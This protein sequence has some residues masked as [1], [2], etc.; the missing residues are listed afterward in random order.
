M[1]TNSE[2]FHSVHDRLMQDAI[3]RHDRAAAARGFDEAYFDTRVRRSD[4]SCCRA[5]TRSI[6][7][8]YLGRQQCL[9]FLPLP[10]W[11]GSFLPIFSR[12]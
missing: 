12:A 3:D 6:D 7:R 10:Q 5:H 4:S 9:Y 8:A 11:Q 2:S 1:T